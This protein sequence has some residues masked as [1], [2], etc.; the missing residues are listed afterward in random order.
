MGRGGLGGSESGGEKK[1]YSS[2]YSPVVVMGAVVWANV[3]G[4]EMP[5]RTMVTTPSLHAHTAS[6]TCWWCAW[7]TST[8]LMARMR[9]PRRAPAAYA[10]P[11][12]S[13][14]DSL[15]GRRPCSVNPNPPGPL[16]MCTTRGATPPWSTSPAANGP[17]PAAAASPSSSWGS[18]DGMTAE[19]LNSSIVRRRRLT[20]PRPL[21]KLEEVEHPKIVRHGDVCVWVRPSPNTA[22]PDCTIKRTDALKP[23]QASP[24]HHTVQPPQRHSNNNNQS[25]KM[26]TNERLRTVATISSGFPAVKFFCVLFF[27]SAH[28]VLV[29]HL[30]PPP[31]SPRVVCV[32]FVIS[33]P[34]EVLGVRL[35]GC[36]HPF[37]G[38]GS[39][40]PGYHVTPWPS[41]LLS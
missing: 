7:T 15:T 41:R 2:T 33:G 13:T 16:V 39:K 5:R 27:F 21:E 24:S 17:G 32:Y 35:G 20:T 11:S 25:I 37:A 40:A 9:S 29:C 36:A 10:A 30:I 38:I 14:P 23:H 12:S 18:R 28:C 6:T 19:Q 8:P 26:M 31:L 1:P 34:S 22:R 4:S 3:R